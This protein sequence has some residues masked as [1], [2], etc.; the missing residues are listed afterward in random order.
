MV[1]HRMSSCM[2]SY[3]T[4]AVGETSDYK[5]VQDIS[6]YADLNT[7]LNTFAHPQ[8]NKVVELANSV[9]KILA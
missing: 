7:L 5:T 4:Y 3:L 6:G 2:H 8:T 9:T 1:L